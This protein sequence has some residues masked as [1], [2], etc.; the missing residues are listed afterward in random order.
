MKRSLK[1]KLRVKRH[2]E[3]N[4]M[5]KLHMHAFFLVTQMFFA[6]EWK[7]QEHL[8][9]LRKF[10]CISKQKVY[11]D[12]Y[13][14][15][16]KVLTVLNL[17]KYISPVDSV[18]A[19]DIQEIVESAKLKRSKEALTVMNT[20][21]ASVSGENLEKSRCKM[22]LCKQLG[23]PADRRISGGKRIRTKILKSESSA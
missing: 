17:R 5:K 8:K 10:T 11:C 13:V 7:N 20:V 2:C 15:I 3:K 21:T 6:T 1:N 12:F 9:I 22:R 16:P 19:S 14:F 23:I 18:I 4:L